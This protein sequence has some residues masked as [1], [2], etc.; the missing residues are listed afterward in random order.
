[1][2]KITK[3][4]TRTGDG[5]TTSLVGGVRIAKDS[6]RIEAYGTMDELSSQLG[7]LAAHLPEGHERA[8]VERVQ[9]NLF[10]VCTYLATDLTQTPLYPSGRLAEG[11]TQRLEREIDALVAEQPEATGFILPGGTVEAAQAHVARAVCRRA[12]RRMVAVGCADKEGQGM[13][14]YVNRLSDYLFVLA[15]KLNNMA[16]RTEKTWCNTCK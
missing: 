6:A 5:G 7:L 1:M 9:N 3:V 11:E 14:R 15:K 8:M 12:E 10:R 16:G 4:Y 2:V 13:L